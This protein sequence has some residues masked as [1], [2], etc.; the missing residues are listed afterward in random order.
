MKASEAKRIL[1]VTQKTINAYIKKGKLHPIKINSNHYEYDEEEV[2]A[3][4]GKGRK[5]KTILYSRVSLRKQK[6]DLESQKKRLY[7]WATSNGYTV[8][9]ELSDIKSGMSF[10]ERPGFCKLIDMVSKR[11]VETVIIENRDRITRFGFEM[12]EHMFSKLGAK[13]LIISNIENKT[14][15]KELTDDLI[16]IIHY[17]SMKAYSMRRKLHI[18]EQVLL[19]NKEVE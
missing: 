6:N 13:I 12:L 7:D 16:S 8:D 4:L 15:E 19:G 10:N 2:F 5:R 14:Y 11:E 1:C 17:Y 18:A 9:E 3:L